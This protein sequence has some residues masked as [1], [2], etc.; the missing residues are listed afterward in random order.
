MN[1]IKIATIVGAR[2]Q[3]IKAAVISR[4]IRL[5]NGVSEVL[6][7]TGQHYNANMSDIFFDELDI[8]TPDHHLG[9]GGGLH[10]QN[11]GRMLELIE[12]VLV[13]ERPDWVLVYG[14]TD[15][16]LAGA[17]AACKLHIPIAHVE[18]GL[19]SYNR[20]MPE[21]I[22]R[23]LTDH[24]S[25]LLFAPTV[26]AVNNL[27]VE[28][29]KGNK[30]H[31][32]GDVMYDAMLFY[33]FKFRKPEILSQSSQG[34]LLCTIH[35]AENTDNLLRLAA[36]VR[37]IN[38][39]SEKWQVIF[40]MHPRTM[41]ALRNLQNEVKLSTN[42]HVTEPLSYLEM[43]WLLENCSAVITDSGG[44]QK[45]A[46]FHLKP[47]VTL[48][49]ETEWVE[50]VSAGYNRLASPFEED[51]LNRFYDFIQIEIPSNDEIYGNGNAGN[52]IV[53]KLTSRTI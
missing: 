39:L 33:K 44:L 45:E 42:V 2:P 11:T 47:C 9:I 26:T 29:I 13:K 14:D 16:T 50:L 18:A 19:R 22:N 8:R 6:I 27:Y 34:F 3:F 48:R 24:S 17:L 52:V 37:F 1:T 32:S 43:N 41:D 51:L 31:L 46:Y 10:G 5:L 30:V 38:H 35:R 20:R 49:D 7:H 21:E 12:K 36:I 28:G 25:S 53:E 15:S 40:P 23:V 4:Q